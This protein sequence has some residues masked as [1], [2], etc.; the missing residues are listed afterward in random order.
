MTTKKIM[1]ICLTISCINLAQARSGGSVVGNGAGI[2]EQNFEYAYLSIEK[3]SEECMQNNACD[4]SEKEK[5]LLQKISKI[6]EK[7]N[8]KPNTILFVSESKHPDFFTTGPAEKNRIAKT[9][10]DASSPI[11]VNRELLYDTDGSPTLNFPAI[12][13]IV[14]HELG[15]QTGETDHKILDALGAKL[16]FMVERRIQTYDIEAS[17][18]NNT[19]V[20]IT[21]L[22]H[23]VNSK[24]DAELNV[25][26]GN[27]YSRS[28]T[29]NIVENLSC[30]SRFDSLIGYEI[31]NG[32]FGYIEDDYEVGFNALIKIYCRST[33]NSP[34]FADKTTIEKRSLSFFINKISNV[35]EFK[36]KEGWFF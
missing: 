10:L 33:L 17:E 27:I 35:R 1:T 4:L 32:H 9:M 11:Y 3:L 36:I 28:L 13:A 18:K 6:T 16:R 12:V 30:I 22:N 7:N 34:E 23:E 2:A 26:W 8:L 31:L 21:V 20:S 14:T 15:H 29:K 5:I 24:K 19:V 25:A